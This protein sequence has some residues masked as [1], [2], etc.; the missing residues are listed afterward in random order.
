MITELIA[1]L[2]WLHVF[3]AALAY[4]MFGA[5]WYSPLLFIKQWLQLTN[6]NPDDPDAKKDMAKTMITSFILL[7]IITIGIALL[8]V[9]FMTTT[10]IAGLKLGLFVGV[11]FS[12]TAISI[13]YVYTRK[14]LKL[15]LIDCGY[16][17]IG[18]GIVGAI[19]GAWS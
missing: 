7:F 5:L 8:Q 19:L 16:Q 14:S 11:I 2:N 12:T 6:M 4:F 18:C 13:N 3:V 10:L 15:Y 17:I 9:Q 1:Q